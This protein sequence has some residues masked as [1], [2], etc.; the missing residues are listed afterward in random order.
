MH[1]ELNFTWEDSY[2]PQQ[3]G[4]TIHFNDDGRDVI[5]QLRLISAMLNRVNRGSVDIFVL[6]C[7]E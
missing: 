3:W 4:V 1:E 2:N 5:I 7:R 6:V